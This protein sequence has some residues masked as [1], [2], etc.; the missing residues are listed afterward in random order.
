MFKDNI[1]AVNARLIQMF[2]QT[3]PILKSEPL[4]H[5]LAGCC[6]MLS[7]FALRLIRAIRPNTR[8]WSNHT[9][10]FPYIFIFFV[11]L[12]SYYNVPAYVLPF[13]WAAE[14]NTILLSSVSCTFNPLWPTPYNY[15]PKKIIIHT[16][17]ETI[18]ILL[19]LNATHFQALH[20]P[21]KV[22][23]GITYKF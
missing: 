3:K 6:Y 1:T 14:R 5:V 7:N 11:H 4:C 19:K 12:S 23:S 13:H 22:I 21:L 2:M 8:I 15:N 16:S 9:T 20:F 17:Q 10:L 18:T